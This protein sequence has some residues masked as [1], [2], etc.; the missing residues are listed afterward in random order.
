MDMVDKFYC[1]IWWAMRDSNSRPPRCKRD[2][3]PAELIAQGSFFNKSTKR[4][5]MYISKKKS[6]PALF[7]QKQQST[8][9][10]LQKPS[11]PRE[12]AAIPVRTISITPYGFN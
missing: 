5:G 2:A 9:T 3:L 7:C 10:S 1:I 12:I 6:F 11:F 8:F 4:I